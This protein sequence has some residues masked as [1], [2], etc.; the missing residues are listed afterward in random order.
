MKMNWFVIVGVVA[1]ALGACQ[2]HEDRERAINEGRAVAAPV[3][4]PAQDQPAGEVAASE[5]PFASTCRELEGNWDAR[6]QQCNVTPAACSNS[7]GVWQEGIGCVFETAEADCAA[8]AG[9]HFEQSK[10]ILRTISP[11]VAEVK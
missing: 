3:S 11:D 1:L 8:T 2:D 6:E 10:C 9:M 5:N 4:T 7:A